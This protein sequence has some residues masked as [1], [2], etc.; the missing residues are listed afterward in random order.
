MA[1]SHG[2]NHPVFALFYRL[3][4]PLNDRG[5]FIEHRRR[6]LAEARG[7]VLEVGVGT[8]L[9]LPLYPP[10]VREILAVEPEPHMRAE[11]EKAAAEAPVP[12]RVIDAPA[13]R[14]PFDDGSIDTVITSLV[15]CSVEDLGA[16]LAEIRRVLLPGGRLLFL[17]HVRAP[18]GSRLQ[19]WQ[20]RL[21]RPWGFVGA[22]CHPNRDIAGAVAGAGFE[23]ESID[24]FDIGGPL[25]PVR[26]HVLGV[27]RPVGE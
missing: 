23:I 19:R 8:G 4:G 17:E 3:L 27:A 10:G 7:R 9:N 1:G 11:A 6:L 13:E 26:P 21:E 5:G 18:E 24:A 15:L 25:V 14:L 16:A 22:G 20:D 12:V 2:A